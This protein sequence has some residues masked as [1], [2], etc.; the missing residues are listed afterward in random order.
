MRP[1]ETKRLAV[2]QHIDNNTWTLRP[3]RFPLAS[4]STLPCWVSRVTVEAS[5][6]AS[7]R[8]AT[9]RQVKIMMSQQP[10]LHLQMAF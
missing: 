4:S 8:D 1:R 5:F 6:E 7:T 10:S 2:A 3:G 9:G